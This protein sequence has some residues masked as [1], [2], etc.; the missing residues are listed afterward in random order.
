MT[1]KPITIGSDRYKTFW[2]TETDFFVKIEPRPVPETLTHREALFRTL[3]ARAW[4]TPTVLVSGG[5]DSE[6]AAVAV[7]EHGAP[8][9]L[10]HVE[11]TFDGQLINSHERYWV[12][13]LAKSLG[14]VLHIISLDVRRFYRSEEYLNWSV[15]YMVQSPQIAAHIWA[16]SQITDPVIM[17]GQIRQGPDSPTINSTYHGVFRYWHTAGKKGMEILQDSYELYELG[18]RLPSSLG[19]ESNRSKVGKRKHF[20]LNSW[21]FHH[22]FVDR[23]KHTGFELLQQQ[24]L[25]VGKDWNREFRLNTLEQKVNRLYTHFV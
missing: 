20:L 2:N 25:S 13:R 7:H 6:L 16:L 10:T 23:P 17:G 5:L 14:K 21:G 3:D 8:Y 24:F 12:E 9:S 22:E 15:P 19:K 1:T 4:H 18:N 11:F